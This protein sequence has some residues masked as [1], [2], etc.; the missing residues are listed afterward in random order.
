MKELLSLN[1]EQWHSALE[2]LQWRTP[3][4]VTNM[5]DDSEWVLESIAGYLGS[6]E[7]VIPVTDFMEHKCT[8]KIQTCVVIKQVLVLYWTL[9]IGL[10]VD[11]WA[12][13]YCYIAQKY[14]YVCSPAGSTAV[15]AYMMANNYVIIVIFCTIICNYQWAGISQVV[16]TNAWL[17]ISSIR[18]H[19]SACLMRQPN[20]LFLSVGCMDR[21]VC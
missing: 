8:G 7:W 16:N 5:A 14:C 18:S 6:P 12:Q 10:H 21:P 11:Q 13:R 1:W 9:V 20:V 4:G 19:S 17:L 2:P 15:I 3:I